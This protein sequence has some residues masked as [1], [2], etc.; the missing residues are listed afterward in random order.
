MSLRRLLA[1]RLQA[2]ELA[3]L[4]RSYDIVG[5]I[6]VIRIHPSLL[7]QAQM[8]GNAVMGVHRHV[9]VVLRQVEGVAGELRLRK[10]E[11]VCGENRTETI[12]REFGCLYKVDLA[13]VY[14]SPRLQHER[15]RVAGLIQPG[16]IVLN[17]F[18]GVGCFSIVIARRSEAARVYSV[19]LNPECVRL[20]VENVSLNGVEG[21]VVPIQGDARDVISSGGVSPVD[22]V[23]LPLP[24]KAL[25]YLDSA[26]NCLKPKG[27]VHLYEFT[28]AGKKEDPVA[29]IE[30]RVKFALD[31]LG[32][33]ACSL[34]GRVVR[35]VG[36]NWYQV[37]VDV[38]IRKG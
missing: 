1:G 7:G 34:R 24:R 26:V 18:A 27:W 11:W 9:K 21:R 5:D 32:V 14:F 10:L 23:L 13:K 31:D 25:D 30:D 3:R 19:D 29:V 38:Q 8:I 6:A 17:M 15:A 12:H 2:E 22:R 37:A 33:F 36:P 4:T 35:S 28:H 20:M 16:E